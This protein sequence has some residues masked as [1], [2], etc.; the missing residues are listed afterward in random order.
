MAESTCFEA[1]EK[2]FQA[3]V[4]V[5]GGTYLQAPNEQDTTRIMAQYIKRE[6]FG[7]FGSI[8]SMHWAWKNYPFAWQGLHKGHIKE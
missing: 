2:F 4:A 6:F 7:M 1:V 3:V 5:F 8:N